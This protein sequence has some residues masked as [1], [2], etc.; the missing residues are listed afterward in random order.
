MARPG[1]NSS[2]S[3][4]LG[5]RPSCDLRSDSS[6]SAGALLM[7]RRTVERW[8]GQGPADVDPR[9]GIALGVVESRV[10]H[11]HQN[12]H[13]DRH[14]SKAEETLHAVLC[15]PLHEPYTMWIVKTRPNRPACFDNLPGV[16]VPCPGPLIGRCWTRFFVRRCI[17]TVQTRICILFAHARPRRRAMSRATSATRTVEI[18]A[19]RQGRGRV[20]E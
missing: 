14:S 3:C 18:S 16:F 1:G 6:T 2:F 20:P 9:Q 7:I 13:D 8:M 5:S 4:V 12:P 17:Y 15:T 11:V 19:Y 10:L